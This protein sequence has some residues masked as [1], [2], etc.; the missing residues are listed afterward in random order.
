[1]TSRAAIAL[2][3]GPA[4]WMAGDLDRDDGWWH[5]CTD[6]EVDEIGAALAGV[7]D[8]NP[9]LDLAR[10]TAADFPL[11]GFARVIDAIRRQL[12]EGRGV[13]VCDGFPVERYSA[14]ELRAIWWGIS[15]HL[16]TPVA[17]SWRGDVLGDVRDLGT[18]VGGRTGRGYTSRAELRFHSDQADAT[19]LFFLRTA[20]RGGAT[21]LASSMAVH[22]EIARRRPD[23]LE[24]LYQPFTVS[25]QANEPPGERP[26][27]DMPVYG[28]AGDDVAC[29]CVAS[30]ILFAE[31]N[32]GAPALSPAQVEAVWMVADVAAE[33]PFWIERTLRPGAMLFVNNHTVFHARTE[34]DDFD[35]PDR[36]RH[37]LRSWL[38]LPNS[39]PLPTSF[40]PLFG[41][42]SAGACR[43]GFHSR[44]GVR[45]FST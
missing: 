10:I 28:R 42:V 38:S 40:A 27:Y 31:Q 13:M 1:M 9:S 34:F 5:A 29:S 14:G 19:A 45:R 37:L 44:D 17:Q 4:T 18:G 39:R 35:E 24:V 16:G 7:A 2:A 33:A 11:P 41:D 8:A 22:N 23:L 6:A 21:R 32:C 26:W 20:R 36:K 3:A 12:V 43:G 15:Q 30:N 25:W